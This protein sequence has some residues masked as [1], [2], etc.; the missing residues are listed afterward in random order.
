MSDNGTVIRIRLDLAYKGTHFK[1]WATQP[2]LR[3]VQGLIEEALEKLCRTP[4]RVTVAGRTD[5]GVHAR[6]QVVHADLPI[7]RWFGFPGR[8]DRT[9]GA[10]LVDKLGALLPSDIVVHS[11]TEAPSGFD[12]RFSA[13]YR[14]YN[15]RIADRTELRD[16]L[17]AD[18]VYWHRYPV[19][20]ELMQAAA[21]PLAGL[22]DFAAFCKPRPGATTIRE[23]K[24]FSW[25]R[26]TSGPDTGLVRATIVADAFCHN[27]VR[28][29]VGASLD[30][31]TGLKPVTWPA[32]M[33]ASKSRVNSSAVVNPQ[34]LTLEHVQ[35]PPDAE[36]A[37]RAHAVRAMR[38]DEEAHDLTT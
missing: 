21:Q 5:A 29:L 1:G 12:A 7:E 14:V 32:Q 38:M 11:A 13:L 18:H 26:V 34:G 28:S 9:P 16:P 4:I 30:V 8:S 22:R 37:S 17:T 31:G 19:D 20:V 6:G 36:L 35:Y 27:M 3:T 23:L 10:A 2:G 25:E 33:L 24:D 15:Y